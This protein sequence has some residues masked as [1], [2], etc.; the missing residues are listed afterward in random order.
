RLYMKVVSNCLKFKAYL[1][2]CLE[3]DIH[4]RTKNKAKNDKIE[5][6]MEKCEKTKSIKPK[7]QQ[8]SQTVKVRVNSE[9]LKQKIQLEGLI[10]QIV[11]TLVLSVLSFIHKN[12]ASSA[13]FWES[14]ILI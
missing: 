8:K 4:K 11:K 2:W 13:S 5:H 1:N 9:R 3:T 7:S 6:G 12:F 14:N 10:S